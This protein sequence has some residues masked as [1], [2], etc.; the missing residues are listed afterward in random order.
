MIRAGKMRDQGLV[1][2]VSRCRVDGQSSFKF[3]PNATPRFVVENDLPEGPVLAL[4][5][6]SPTLQGCT[7]VRSGCGTSEPVGRFH[8]DEGAETMRAAT[9]YFAGAGTVIAA[10]VC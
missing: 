4:S 1:A 3:H 8:P 5:A 6:M 10:I 9:A 2:G 7:L